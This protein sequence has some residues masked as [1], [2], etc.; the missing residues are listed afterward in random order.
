M[1][2]LL[3]VRALSFLWHGKA[4]QGQN[5]GPGSRPVL[6]G[7]S[8][9]SGRAPSPLCASG[10]PT[11]KQGTRVNSPGAPSHSI[12]SPSGFISQSL[13]TLDRDSRCREPLILNWAMSGEVK[14]RTLTGNCQDVKTYKSTGPCFQSSSLPSTTHYEAGLPWTPSKKAW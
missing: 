8:C 1:G 13:F 2:P 9:G 11:A 5:C 7:Q 12:T 4:C 3:Q 10:L 6:H 14:R